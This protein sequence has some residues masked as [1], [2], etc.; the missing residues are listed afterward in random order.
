[1]EEP[2]F[3]DFLRLVWAIIKAIAKVFVGFSRKL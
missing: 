1:M 2:P 3:F